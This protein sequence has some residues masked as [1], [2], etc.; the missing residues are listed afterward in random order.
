MGSS[1]SSPQKCLTLHCSLNER[2][3]QG[4]E[5]KKGHDTFSRLHTGTK[6]FVGV[7]HGECDLDQWRGAR[8]AVIKPTLLGGFEIAMYLARK[9]INLGMTP[10]ISS[11]FESPVGLT[12]LGHLAA[13]V[14]QDEVAAG[15]DT[16]NWFAADLLDA[17][18]PIERGRL[19]LSLADALVH[20]LNT[21]NLERLGP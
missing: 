20:R 11:S 2:V 8:A 6:A 3:V 7:E 4:H 16:W 19:N 1:E 18:A 5:T 12:A 9:A 15:L 13:F 17:P 14:N 10:V 21:D